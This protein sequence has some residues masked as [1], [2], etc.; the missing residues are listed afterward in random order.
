MTGKCSQRHL[1]FGIIKTAQS[2]QRMLTC[3]SKV[4][5]PSTRP[6]LQRGWLNF[7]FSKQNGQ[8]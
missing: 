8:R 5:A 1:R 7:A 6:R 2:V 3:R 4:R